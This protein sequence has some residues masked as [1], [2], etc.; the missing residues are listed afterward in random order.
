[1][2]RRA[3]LGL[4]AGAAADPERLLWVPGKRRIFIPPAPRVKPLYFGVDPGMGPDMTMLSFA[5][6]PLWPYGLLITEEISRDEFRRRYP[7]TRLP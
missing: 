6:G 2:T 1:M 3:L 4:L 7:S 5:A